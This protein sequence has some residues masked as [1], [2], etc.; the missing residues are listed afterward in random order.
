MTPH[1]IPPP[2]W[3]PAV[4]RAIPPAGALAAL[5]ACGLAA[6][7][8]LAVR[9]DYDETADFSALHTWAWLPGTGPRGDLGSVD[10]ELLDKEVRKAVE[11]DLAK[12]G[13]VYQPT[14]TPDFWVGY[15]ALVTRQK[16]E[17]AM[18]EYY[19]Y[20]GGLG[21]GSGGVRTQRVSEEYEQGNLVLDV[22]TD[23]GNRLIWRGAAQSRLMQ[24]ATRDQ[25]IARL[26]EAVE[27]ILA[28]FPP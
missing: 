1:R 13:F 12:K 27:K 8:T 14:G 28:S 16:T 24:S 9:S 7:T 20:A 17:K 2:A 25:R 11:Q 23:A 21:Y 26:H 10:P 19:G 18:N 22:S 5:L 15:H 4:A 3:A 6:C